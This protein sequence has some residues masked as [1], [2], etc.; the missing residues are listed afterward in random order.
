MKK[1]IKR[2]GVIL[3]AIFV[4]ATSFLLAPTNVFADN[5]TCETAIL[6]QEWCDS[7]DPIMSIISFVARLLFGGMTV[8]AVIGVIICGI[9]YMTARDNEQ[10][11]AK[12]KK[13]LADVVVGL[14]ILA[15]IDIFINILLPGAN[16]VQDT[17]QG[18]A[19]IK[20]DAAQ[21]LV[22]DKKAGK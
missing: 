12:A 15:L 17:I 20:T 10:Q 16:G 3:L 9:M 11:V 14:V 22:L 2:G 21:M 4:A 19:V 7:S 8:I 5:D 18:Q 1:G 13:R 6:P